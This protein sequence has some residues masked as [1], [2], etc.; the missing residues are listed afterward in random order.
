M[1]EGLAPT[2][3]QPADAMEAQERVM[4]AL[5]IGKSAGATVTDDD[6][7]TIL[8]QGQLITMEIAHAVRAAGKLY[9][10]WMAAQEEG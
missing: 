1:D 4:L 10:V 6:G 9:E 7:R 2:A 8:E 5:V 3:A